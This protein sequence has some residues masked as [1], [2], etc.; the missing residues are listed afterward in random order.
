MVEVHDFMSLIS[1]V[2]HEG[3]TVGEVVGK[4]VGK[5]AKI[6]FLIFIWL[7]LVLVVAVFAILVANTF[8]A[9]SSVATA[10]VLMLGIAF[11]VKICPL[12]Q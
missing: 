12:Q 8:A 10:S 3:K 6:L 1:S 9:S 5:K 4:N 11:I 7:A 2:R